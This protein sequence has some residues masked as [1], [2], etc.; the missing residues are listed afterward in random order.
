MTD[1]ERKEIFS[2]I[3]KI[4]QFGFA[5]EGGPLEEF[6]HWLRL[7]SLLNS[8]DPIKMTNQEALDEAQRRWPEHGGVK[9][10]ALMKYNKLIYTVGEIRPYFNPSYKKETKGEGFSWEEAFLNVGQHK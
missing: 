9:V 10:R 1:A 6:N 4:E 7:K 5:C 2:E 3:K 8:V